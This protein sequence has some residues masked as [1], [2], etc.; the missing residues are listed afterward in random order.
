M[1]II[2]NLAVLLGMLIVLAGS[3]VAPMDAPAVA[4]VD[5][6]LKRALLTYGT[7][8]T[9]SGILST[10]QAAQIDIQPAG[11]GVTLSPGQILAPANEMI[12]QLADVMLLASVAFGV[13]KIFI[14]I[15]GY[16]ALSL[17]LTGVVL[18]WAFCQY[19]WGSS[20]RWLSG[21]LVF[22][23]ALRFA[24][25]LATLG[26]HLISQQFLANEFKTAQAA[27]DA[28]TGEAGRV[29]S[30]EPSAVEGK[31]WIPSMPSW[32]PSVADIKDR[33]NKLYQA[34]ERSTEHVIRLM[35]VFL[36][37]TL[38]LPLLFLWAVIRVARLAVERVGV[39]PAKT[40]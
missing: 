2:R 15:G 18:A 17:V 39:L 3:W 24:I 6:G 16:W 12:K 40:A 11:L 8:R 1:K 5:A 23:L 36:L 14:T 30:P 20:P 21:A 7:A 28:T 31:S 34:I 38:I 9:A 4:Q 26:T 33:Y 29:K 25:P 10:L 22:V 19:R 32:V 13:Q 27:I 35:V 37:E